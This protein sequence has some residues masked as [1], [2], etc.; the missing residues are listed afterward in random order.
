MLE[1]Q[2]ARVQVR[3]EELVG[4]LVNG[5]RGKLGGVW[6]VGEVVGGGVGGEGAS[7]RG[8]VGRLLV[9]LLLHGALLDVVGEFGWRH[10]GR[11]K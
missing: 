7:A 6:S 1:G 10:S 9:H 3:A 5:T 11:E 8:M 2:L 4:R